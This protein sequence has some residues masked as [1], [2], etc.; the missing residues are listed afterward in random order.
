MA[1]RMGMVPLGYPCLQEWI[2][3]PLQAPTCVRILASPG[4]VLKSSCQYWLSYHT[5]LVVTGNLYQPRSRFEVIFGSRV[6][7]PGTRPEVCTPFPRSSAPAGTI[8]LSFQY[9]KQAR[10]RVAPERYASTGHGIALLTGAK[11]KGKDGMRGTLCRRNAFDPA[12]LFDGP[13]R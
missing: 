12:H 5:K 3:N 7:L 2:L 13:L 10:R 1:S 9:G 4:S 6:D 8:T 11:S